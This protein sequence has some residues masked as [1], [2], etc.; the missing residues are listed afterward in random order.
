[1]PAFGDLTTLDDV[2]AW[3]VLA[4]QGT[5]IPP[6]DEPMIDR[7]ITHATDF[8]EWWIGRRIASRDWVAMRDGP[9]TPPGKIETRFQ[10]GEYPASAVRSVSILNRPVPAIPQGQVGLSSGYLFSPT[11]LI[12]RGF[13]VPRFAQCVSF[14]YTAGYNPIP[15]AL[16]QACIA[17]VAFKYRERQHIGMRTN[18]LQGGGQ[19]YTYQNFSLK[20][21]TTD[22]QAELSPFRKAA[23]VGGNDVMAQLQTDPAIIAAV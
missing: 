13:H 2:K 8:I 6:G 21:L 19:V 16:T 23:P 20:D 12:I 18:N 22:I 17:L 5:T 7:L 9:G 15:G 4:G 11:Q 3:L 14:G 1:M 10:F